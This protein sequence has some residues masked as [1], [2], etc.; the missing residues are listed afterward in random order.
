MKQ[1]R[2]PFVLL[3]ATSDVICDVALSARGAVSALAGANWIAIKKMMLQI[4]R[5]RMLKLGPH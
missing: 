4:D 2:P 1:V 5:C 3:R